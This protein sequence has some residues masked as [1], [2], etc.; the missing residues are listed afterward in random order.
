MSTSKEAHSQ[1]MLSFCD[2]WRRHRNNATCLMCLLRRPEYGLPCGHIFCEVDI[3][4]FGKEVKKD[5]FAVN[6]C[7]LCSKETN[8][9]KFRLKPRTKGISIL[10]IDGG[11]V[12][13]IIPLQ[14]LQL[15]E[16]KLKPYLSEFP[17]QNH[18]DMTIG[19]SSGKYTKH[20]N[21]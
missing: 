21:L 19:T 2:Q 5:T 8:E 15:L 11:G 17:V 4:R 18:F 20:S 9:A 10:G 6:A 14:L 16:L 3:R 13:G 7:F 12:K 1:M